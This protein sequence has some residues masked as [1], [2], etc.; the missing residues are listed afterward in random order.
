MQKTNFDKFNFLQNFPKF[1]KLKKIIEKQ[2]N[3]LK[4]K[5][6]YLK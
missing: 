2:L 5:N 3:G 1:S 6:K 4:S